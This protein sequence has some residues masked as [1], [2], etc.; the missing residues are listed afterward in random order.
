MKKEIIVRIVA[1]YGGGATCNVYIDD[2]QYKI[3]IEK[4]EQYIKK[5]I[6]ECRYMV[7]DSPRLKYK[8]IELI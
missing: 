6:S 4:L 1:G 7:S 2:V 3:S 5:E 8:R